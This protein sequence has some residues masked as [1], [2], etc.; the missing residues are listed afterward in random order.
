[1]G[2][3]GLVAFTSFLL[4]GFWGPR[5]VQRTTDWTFHH[6]LFE[7]TRQTC[8]K[9][10]KNLLQ[11]SKLYSGKNRLMVQRDLP[12]A[13]E[14]V[15][16]SRRADPE[17][18]RVHYQFAYIYLQR[19]EP[20]KMEPELADALWC[21]TTGAQAGSLWQRYWQLVLSGQVAPEN[22]GQPPPSREEAI[23]RQE[24]LIE[25]SQRKHMRMQ[26]RRQRSPAGGQQESAAKRNEL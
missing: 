3:I 23:Q 4:I 13:L 19:E 7:R 21:P 14:L 6:L 8:P 24:K 1:M 17:F 16:E 25:T 11:L 15:E 18:C 26:N 5:V 10:A 9:S 2:R 20:S 22:A 12:R